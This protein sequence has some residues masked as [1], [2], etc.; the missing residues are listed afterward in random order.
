MLDAQ[1]RELDDAQRDALASLARLTMTL[2]EARARERAL[3]HE[4]FIAHTAASL[5]DAESQ[6]N[7]RATNGAGYLLVLIE[8]QDHAG[9]VSRLGER[10]TDKL[11]QRLDDVLEQTLAA[12]DD[13]IT[14]SSG[15]AEFVA[16]LHGEHAPQTLELLRAAIAHEADPQRLQFLYG[17]AHGNTLEST[18]QVFLCADADLIDQ[19]GAPATN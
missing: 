14:R 11:L 1:P 16:V 13:A 8:L 7:T 6:A 19:K 9:T 5:V 15:S 12:G 10:T 2:L 4:N 3:E 17:V 18:G